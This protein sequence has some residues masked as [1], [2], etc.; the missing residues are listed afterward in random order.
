MHKKGKANGETCWK[1]FF[2]PI[3]FRLAVWLC[4]PSTVLSQVYLSDVLNQISA[5]L[6]VKRHALNAVISE[7][8]LRGMIQAAL[9]YDTQQDIF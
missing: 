9:E 8:I 1:T 2:S 6:Q 3:F 5:T 7:Q 4:C